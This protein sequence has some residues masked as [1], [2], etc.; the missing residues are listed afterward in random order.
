MSNDVALFLIGGFVFLIVTF[1]GF[2]IDSDKK[3]AEEEKKKQEADKIA[4][5]AQYE[6]AKKNSPVLA[7]LIDFAFDHLN[8]CIKKTHKL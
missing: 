1:T 5:K 3:A 2:I 7:A 8:D 4:R 6:E